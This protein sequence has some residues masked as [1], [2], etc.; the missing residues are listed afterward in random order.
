MAYKAEYKVE[1][2]ILD[3]EVNQ[4]QFGKIIIENIYRLSGFS[5]I[6]YDVV[7]VIKQI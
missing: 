7:I 1:L 3:T 2:I 4:I 5:R 6:Y